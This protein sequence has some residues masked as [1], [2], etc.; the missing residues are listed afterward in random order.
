MKETIWRAKRL[1]REMQ[2]HWR[3]YDRVE[4]E[5]RRRMEKEA[6]EQRKM[7]VELMEVLYF[8]ECLYFLP[9]SC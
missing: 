2:S 8:N 6:E 3:R 4:R 7:D 1:S 5:T 9:I